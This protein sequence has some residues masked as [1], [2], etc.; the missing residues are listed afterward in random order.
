MAVLGTVKRNIS[1]YKEKE[2]SALFFGAGIITLLTV[3]FILRQPA[4]FLLQRDRYDW[5][6]SLFLLYPASN[7]LTH[8]TSL[9]SKLLHH[10]G[11]G[12]LTPSLKKGFLLLFSGMI[13]FVLWASDMSRYLF[14]LNRLF[15][16]EKNFTNAYPLPTSKTPPELDHLI[17]WVSSYQGKEG[18]LLLEDSHH[19]RHL[20]WGSHL[21]AIL[22]GLTQREI[23]ASPHPEHPQRIAT[24]GLIDGHLQGKPLQE[25]TDDAFK[26][27]LRR[28]NIRWI[29]AHSKLTTQF[30]GRLS[31]KEIKKVAT[32][33]HF[34]CYEIEGSSDY[35]LRG[36]GKISADFNQIIL[37]DLEA[38]SG[39]VII[40][41]HW[42]P[43]L[44]TEPPLPVKEERIPESPFGFIKIE[45]P[46]KDLR[47]FF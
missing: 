40:K 13:F 8:K 30:L 11:E 19:P 20:Y 27:Y 46:P 9:F 35:F 45:N 7:Y 29:V 14:A 26:A 41:Y 32:F 16:H 22:P 6:L 2:N 10:K 43:G 5:L 39:E 4:A 17:G 38:T 36:T 31:S 28:Y 47:I 24:L 23:I 44:R 18:R 21:P 33:G 15:I 1:G 25:W 37:Q 42:F 3:M 12:G 34:S